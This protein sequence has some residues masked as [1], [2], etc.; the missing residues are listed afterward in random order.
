MNM[1]VKYFISKNETL[2][3]SLGIGNETHL[4]DIISPVTTVKATQKE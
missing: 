2:K 3:Q 1:P 4:V